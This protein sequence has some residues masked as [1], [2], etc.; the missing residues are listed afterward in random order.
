[1]EFSLA[2]AYAVAVAVTGMI[3]WMGRRNQQ[4]GWQRERTD[5]L[6]D[7]LTTWAEARQLNR[8]AEPA[9]S[10]ALTR[11]RQTAAAQPL[12]IPAGSTGLELLALQTVLN[13]F[14]SVP[15]PG[16][17]VESEA[18]SGPLAT[19]SLDVVLQHR[20]SDRQDREAL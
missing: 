10:S 8:S 17:P 15:G 18:E 14:G 2:L 20:V 4:R 19:K 13:S 6:T 1:M 11:S 16:R 7:I 9:P 3:A 5:G 12:Q